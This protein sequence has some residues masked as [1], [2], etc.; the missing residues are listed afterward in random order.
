[1]CIVL[2]L[3][4]GCTSHGVFVFRVDPS[5]CLQIS[6][7]TQHRQIVASASVRENHARETRPKTK[8]NDGRQCCF[9]YATFTEYLLRVFAGVR[10]DRIIMR[11]DHPPSAASSSYTTPPPR[12]L[13]GNL[14]IFFIPALATHGFR[15]TDS[16]FRRAVVS[17]RRPFV[18]SPCR[19]EPAVR[20]D[21]LVLDA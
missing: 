6:T 13:L 15:P 10:F 5:K 2:S 17:S 1:M 16:T 12:F 14:D 7:Y 4:L 19:S 11:R 20:V 3:L 18:L 21:L 8:S 9:G